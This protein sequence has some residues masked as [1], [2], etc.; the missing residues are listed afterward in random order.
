[1]GSVSIDGPTYFM[2]VIL[3]IFGAISLPAVRR[4]DRGE[5]GQRLRP[6]GRRRARHAGGGRRRSAAG[7]EHTEVYPLALF[8]LSGMMLFPASTDLITMFVALEILSLPLYLLCGLARRRRLLSQEAALKYFLLGA[9]SSAFFLYGVA[10]LYGYAGSFDL[11]AIDAALRHRHRR[12]AAAAGR[13]GPARGRPA[14]QVRRRAVPLLD[15]G[16]V[17]R[18]ARPPVT[19]FM[20]ACTKIAAIGALMRVFY[21]A[22]GADR[23]DWQPL[24]AI[25]AVAT[26][27]VGSVVAITQTDVKRMLAYSSIAHAGFLMTAFVGAS[28]A[29]SGIRPAV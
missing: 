29:A 4:P 24:M 25:V 8:A 9:L 10:L 21:V 14:V 5:R 17:R 18:R 13:H 22:L 3:L 7:V 11:A 1:M 19:A 26:M 27:A 6:A 15:P 20:A 12:L 23:W 16:R 28:Q 2:W